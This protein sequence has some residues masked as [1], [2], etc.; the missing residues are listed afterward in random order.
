MVLNALHIFLMKLIT[1]RNKSRGEEVD[2]INLL[3]LINF[4]YIKLLVMVHSICYIKFELCSIFSPDLS[5]RARGK[6]MLFF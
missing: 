1:Q 3:L 6:E 2:L 5:V 4:P